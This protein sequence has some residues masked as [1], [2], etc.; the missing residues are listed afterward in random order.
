M[1]HWAQIKP[2]NKTYDWKQML[3]KSILNVWAKVDKLDSPGLS[4]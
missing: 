2:N 1:W 3:N 4:I